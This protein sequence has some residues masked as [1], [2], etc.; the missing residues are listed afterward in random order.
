MYFE[1][2]KLQI[3]VTLKVDVFFSQFLNQ[4]FMKLSQKLLEQSPLIQHDKD[5]LICA[6]IP[7]FTSGRINITANIIASIL[8]NALGNPSMH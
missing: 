2:Q 6:N 7:C 4:G 8:S 1:H 3:R 5:P